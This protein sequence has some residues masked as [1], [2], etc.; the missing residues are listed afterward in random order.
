MVLTQSPPEKIIGR[1]NALGVAQ[2]DFLVKKVAPEDAPLYLKAAD[3][4]LSLIK[5]CY[6]KM[7]SS[8]TKIA[9]YLASGLPI[10]TNAGIGD[11]DDVIAEDNVGVILDAFNRDSYGRALK[12]IKDLLL[13]QGIAERCRESARRRFDLANVGG[14][15]YRRL[16]RKVF[17]RECRADVSNGT[18]GNFLG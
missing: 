15:R 7:S 18:G 14:V 3:F 16:Y 9:E 8:P 17:E 4:A 10:I 1:L 2:S 13:E 5:P 6:S 11:L 12:G